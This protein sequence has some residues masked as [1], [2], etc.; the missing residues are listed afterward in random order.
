M[1]SQV[2][3][4]TTSLT[5]LVVNSFGCLI[6]ILLIANSSSA[7]A[8]GSITLENVPPAKP[9][10]A[11]EATRTNFSA[12]QAARYLD[13]AS[14]NWQKANGCVTC[15]T[16]MSYLM[17]RP[18]LTHALADSGDVRKFFESYYQERWDQGK[19]S[20]TLGYNPVVVA[21]GLS[22]NDAMTSGQLSNTTRK[23]LDTMWSTQRNDG[24][25]NWAKCGWAPMEIDDH[26]GVTLALLAAGIAPGNYASSNAARAGIAKSKRYLAM[27]PPPSLHHRLMIAWASIHVEELMSENDRQLILKK[28]LGM[29][30]PDGGW[31]TPAFLSDWKDFKRKDKKPH[32]VNTSDAYGT[33]LA[34]IIAR[35]LGTPASD[36]NLRKGISWLKRNQR[37]SGKWFTPSPT[38]NSRNY[39]TNYG[40]SF[41][42]LALQSCDELP[43]WPFK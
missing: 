24:G 26:Y 4:S 13:I 36:A 32:D 40:T 23:T 43:G 11:S 7:Q 5:T 38:K 22:F 21:T 41:A 18:A 33:G 29:Q 34:I 8:P 28:L 6:A 9:I 3:K 15:H 10:V 17:A 37:E 35:E 25:W 16:N 14:L 42:V 12:E 31:S 39:F 30:R 27:N 20:P 2:T 19:N 1:L